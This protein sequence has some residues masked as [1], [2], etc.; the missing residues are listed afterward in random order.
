MSD[1]GDVHYRS[2]LHGDILDLINYVDHQDGPTR[3]RGATHG[4]EATYNTMVSTSED[5]S[6]M[7][8]QGRRWTNRELENKRNVLAR[9]VQSYRNAM[10]Q[11]PDEEEDEGYESD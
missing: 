3:M 6:L 4:V 7:V 8:Q 10:A 2:I 5:A 11:L 9:H 1:Y